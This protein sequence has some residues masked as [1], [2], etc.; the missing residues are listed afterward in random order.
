MKNSIHL[1]YWFNDCGFI[2]FQTSDKRT[3]T[4]PATKNNYKQVVETIKK[5]L[6]L[7]KNDTTEDIT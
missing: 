6:G 7:T 2:Q 5:S 1:I 3:G 4:Q